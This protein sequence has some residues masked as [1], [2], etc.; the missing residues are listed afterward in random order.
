ML[1]VNLR[2]LYLQLNQEHFNGE[3]P[4]DLPV[5][6]NTR[7]RTTAGKCHYKWHNKSLRQIDAKKI[8]LN[9][10]I[11]DTEEKLRKTLIHEMVHAW[12]A[13]TTHADHGHN[14]WFQSKMDSIFG[15]KRSH[16]CHNYDVSNVS[17]VH[18]VCPNHGVIE[19]RARMPRSYNLH[20]YHCNS[21]GSRVTFVDNRPKTSGSLRSS[22]AVKLF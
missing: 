22:T 2:E 16:R 7:L 21:C 10:H 5:I 17:L 4:E 15:Y 14:E 1:S 9:P 11:L 3:C 19:K 18:M 8:T 6:W 20:R 13:H 12:L